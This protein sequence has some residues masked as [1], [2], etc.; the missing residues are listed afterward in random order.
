MEQRKGSSN[1][2][3][4]ARENYKAIRKLQEKGVLLINPLESEIKYAIKVFLKNGVDVPVIYP[5][6]S[7][8]YST[9]E[10]L[11]QIKKLF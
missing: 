10:K 8:N 4:G 1:D 9:Q 6:F 11:E 7:T 2:I 3:N 5:Y